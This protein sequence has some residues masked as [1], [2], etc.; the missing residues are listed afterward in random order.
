MEIFHCH[1]KW[2]KHDRIYTA[3]LKRKLIFKTRSPDHLGKPCF[4]KE[5]H[6]QNHDCILGNNGRL[7]PSGGFQTLVGNLHHKTHYSVYSA[8]T[9]FITSNPYTFISYV[10]STKKYLFIIMYSYTKS[11]HLMTRHD[12]PKKKTHNLTQPMAKRLKLSGITCFS[13]KI[14]RLNFYL[15]VQDGWVRMTLSPEKW[16]VPASIFNHTMVNWY[17]MVNW[18]PK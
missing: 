18:H 9:T 2:P 17:T 13:G 8:Y 16:H 11:K 7:A 6:L 5:I 14:S 15:R 12:P 1:L 10:A 4:Q 3:C